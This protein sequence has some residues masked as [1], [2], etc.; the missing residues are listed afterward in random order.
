MKPMLACSAIPLLSD[1]RYP[2]IAEP[3]LDGIRCLI[4]NGMPVSRNLKPIPN[5]HI[6]NCLSN[7]SG[8]EGLD[9][10]LI[11]RSGDFNSVQSAIMSEMGTPDFVY[12]VFDD[13]SINAGYKERIEQV[14]S[15][16]KGYEDSPYIQ[17]IPFVLCKNKEELDAL[18]KH[19]LELGY[20]GAIVRDP[21]GPYKFGRST[22]KQ[23]W[24]LKLKNFNDDEAK[25]IGFEE[26][27]HNDNEATIDALGHQVRS[28]HN[29][30]KV[31]GNVL[32]ALVCE[33]RGQTFKI[34]TGFTWDQRANLWSKRGTLIDQYVT[35]KYQELSS[36]GVPRFPVYK[37]FRKGGD[38]PC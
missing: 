12:T 17:S 24:M 11:L 1:I 31:P 34:G 35:F 5:L 32:G 26:L 8:I 33:F 9:G 7:I 2:V 6:R 20:E 19:W 37:G 27:M 13:Y 15:T 21:Y 28:A 18:Y 30:G 3:K 25:V 29:E 38:L 36:Y 16:F 14:S 10:E 22:L 4:V 23:G